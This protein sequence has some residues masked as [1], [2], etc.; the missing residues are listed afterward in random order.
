MT[1]SFAVGRHLGSLLPIAVTLLLVG[2]ADTALHAQQLDTADYASLQYRHIGPP[3]N[4]TSAVVGG[5]DEPRVGVGQ[6]LDADV[7]R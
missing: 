1:L 6:A 7:V 4:R 5:R 2:A 3:G